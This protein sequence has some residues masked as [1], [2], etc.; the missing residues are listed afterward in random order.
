MTLQYKESRKMNNENTTA[1][2]EPNEAM[3]RNWLMKEILVTE[4][5]AFKA[6]A[7][8]FDELVKWMDI[9][10]DSSAIEW[11]KELVDLLIKL[12]KRA[13]ELK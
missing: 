7:D 10:D 11:D 3:E 13:K 5:D 2:K 1:V 8:M 12:N 6:K 4:Y 9:V